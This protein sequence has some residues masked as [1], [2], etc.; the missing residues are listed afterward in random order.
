MN[1]PY[2]YL[3]YFLSIFITIYNSIYILIIHLLGY[4]N[5]EQYNKRIQ[6]WANQVLWI[7]KVKTEVYNPHQTNPIE[8]QPTIIMCNHSSFFDIPLSIKAFPNHS[9]RMLAKK[10][11]SNIP[12]LGAAMKA[13]GYPFIDRKNKIQAVKDLAKVKALLAEG[14]VMWIAPEGTRSK[15]GHLGPFKKGGFITAIEMQAKIIPIAIRGANQILAAHTNE[16]KLNQHASI[17]IGQAINASDYTLQNKD[18]LI[19]R[20]RQTMSELLNETTVG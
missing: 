13:A 17:H 2:S 7:T 20:V 16:L 19:K 1:K 9:I 12:L 15:D 3:I 8:G 10:E 5:R 18:E 14:I 4:G 11:L 6:K